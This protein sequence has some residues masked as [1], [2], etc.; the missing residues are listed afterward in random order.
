MEAEIGEMYRRGFYVVKHRIF[1]R[2]L[3]SNCYKCRL[4]RKKAETEILGPSRTL[5]AAQSGR[6]FA[7]SYADILGPVKIKKS[8][9]GPPARGYVMVL[10]CIWSRFTTFVIME[11]ITAAT[12]LK[13]I[14]IAANTAGGSV[15]STLLTD[16]GTQFLPVQDLDKEDGR[17]IIRDLKAQLLRHKITLKTSSPKAAWRQSC[18]EK[19]VDLFKRALDRA[20]L[21]KKSYSVSDWQF[22]CSKISLILNQR[23]LSIKYFKQSCEIITPLNCLFGRRDNVH[24]INFDLHDGSGGRLYAEV[25]NLDKDLAEFQKAWYYVYGQETLKWSKW[26][27]SSR[28]LKPGDV[29]LVLD[30]ILPE[31]GSPTLGIIEK[32]VS[33]GAQR[34][35]KILYNKKSARVDPQSYQIVRSSKKSSF[36]RPKQGIVFITSPTEDGT[37]IDV[38]PLMTNMDETQQ[39]DHTETL[40]EDDDDLAGVDGDIQN[41]PQEDEV[42]VEEEP[43]DGYQDEVPVNVQLDDDIPLM[44]DI[45]SQKSKH[46]KPR[47]IVKVSVPSK[48]TEKIKNLSTGTMPSK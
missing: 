7:T 23:I 26:H 34:T 41:L 19:M 25:E 2:H 42:P 11:N 1:L 30:R 36:L 43:D 10:S 5:T 13:S 12:V 9:T 28:Q 32:I 20:D 47:K 29:V 31:S 3:A 48:S 17:N 15:P 4:M 8:R 6:V 40:E 14:L 37:M 22:I 39:Q 24:P 18:A 45:R 21:K 46:Q 38:D 44:T 33:T 35:F 16:F 27:H